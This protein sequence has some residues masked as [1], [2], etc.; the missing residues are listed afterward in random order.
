M[1]RCV[2]ACRMTSKSG[3]ENPFLFSCDDRTH[4]A[5]VSAAYALGHGRKLG[6]IAV[7]PATLRHGVGDC[8]RPGRTPLVPTEALR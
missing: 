2:S 5:P 4:R 1:M 3:A 6:A 8:D 7:N